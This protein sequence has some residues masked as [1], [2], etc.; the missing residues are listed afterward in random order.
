MIELQLRV[1]AIRA[2][3]NSKD[4]GSP[5]LGGHVEHQG[6]D[7]RVVVAVDDEA[8]FSKPLAEIDSVLCQQLHTLTA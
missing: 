1:P 8:H 2:V 3:V 7:G 4:G 6:Y 5:Y